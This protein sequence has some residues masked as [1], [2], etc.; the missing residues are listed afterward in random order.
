MTKRKSSSGAGFSPA[1]ALV[2]VKQTMKEMVEASE[3]QRL[4]QL[5]DSES[6]DRERI[7]AS[8][9]DH[10]LTL[11]HVVNVLTD[12]G[13]ICRCIE[14]APGE[15]FKVEEDMVITIGGDGT[16]LDASH[17]ILSKIPVLGV[18][19]A[20]SSS[21]GHYCLT[22]RAGFEKA[23][24]GILA[25][26][27]KFY[28]LNRL[29]LIL[30]GKTLPVPVLNEVFVSHKCPAGTTRYKLTIGDLTREKKCSGL[31]IAPAAGTSG[32][33]QSAGGVLLDITSRKIAFATLAPFRPPGSDSD[34]LR[35][36]IKG[37]SIVS[38]VSEMVQ[39]AIYIDGA[40]I[41]FDFPRGAVLTVDS[42]APSLNAFIN[43]RCHSRYGETAG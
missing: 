40:H 37:G 16:F 12:R 5:L 8:D 29:R 1:R 31:I 22:D 14:R 25:G 32:F 15:S 33:N 36:Y 41:S 35:G 13:I 43:P 4:K 2:I 26:S 6:P 10:R 7:I 23:L 42:K 34:L 9:R 21:H 18:N 24:D 20:P 30:D 3:D 28:A 38:V 17:S 11:E 19:S 39:G 27:I